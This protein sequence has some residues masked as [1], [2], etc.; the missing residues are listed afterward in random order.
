MSARSHAPGEIP[1]RI[2]PDRLLADLYH[3]RRFGGRAEDKGVVRPA[4]SPAYVAAGKW[5]A[6]KYREAGL[7][8]VPDRYGN[9]FGCDPRHD[10]AILLGSHGDTQMRGGWLDGAMGVIFA[11]E[12]ARAAQDCGTALPFG[13]DAVCWN[14]EEARFDH[15][16]GSR[17]YAGV[18]PEGVLDTAVDAGGLSLRAAIA[19]A[20]YAGLPER[21]V[22]V[23]RHLAYLEG[24]IEQGPLLDATGGQLGA[25]EA[26]AG[27]KEFTVTFAGEANH[28]GTTPMALR[29]DAVLALTHALAELDR[30]Y[31]ASADDRIV[32]TFGQIDVTP[33][34]ASIVPALARASVQF[35][36]PNSDML[37][38]FET[39]LHAVL[40][41]VDG[42]AG[43]R[44]QGVRQN[45][46]Y[47][48]TPMDPRLTDI[49]A[50]AAESVAP[51][52]SRRMP[53]GAGHDAQFL[54]PLMPTGMIFVPSIGGISHSFDEDTRDEDIVAG[55]LAM[56][57]AV[58]ALLG[59]QNA[60][61][62]AERSLTGD[63]A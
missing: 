11:L 24:H 53:S 15:F 37:T 19:A 56:A 10:R 51:G 21:P 62:L 35:R 17:A 46:D 40:Q 57:R 1:A 58:D 48:P 34:A 36:A 12:I 33:N 49:I 5:M 16:V 54:A 14:E 28:A 7:R 31:R 50:A 52:R 27:A 38:R 32:W 30:R 45:L 18:L 2:N 55:A 6:D 25:V 20:G 8:A 41:E 23:S 61:W 29:K 43:A 47:R 44:L 9:V 59:P 42:T 63:R 60:S 13:I 4:F 3:L 39:I 26:I 22:P